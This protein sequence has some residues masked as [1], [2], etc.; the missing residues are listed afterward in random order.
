MNYTFFEKTIILSIIFLIL[1]LLF[2][3]I[4]IFNGNKF[5][6][7]IFSILSNSLLFISLSRNRS[8]FEIFFSLLLWLG[9]W[10]KLS[11]VLSFRDYHKNGFFEYA[12]SN[13]IDTSNIDSDL[14]QILLILSIVFFILNIFFILRKRILNFNFDSFYQ[15]N[16]FNQKEKNLIYFFFIN[17][18]FIFI[19]I[20]INDKFL[21]FKKGILQNTNDYSNFFL[22]LKWYLIFGF[23]S[24]FSFILFEFIKTAKKST[25]F[26]ILLVYFSCIYFV[27]I[28]SNSRSMPLILI[29][30]IVG[31]IFSFKNLNKNYNKFIF[32]LV[33]FF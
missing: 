25:F 27:S 8:F 23:Y 22:I 19:I 11:F 15:V 10:F 29:V 6:Y 16:N 17:L 32:L 14:S 4:Y 28:S 3:T 21:F 9:F 1:A 30:I 24:V 13:F 18:I 33:V 12:T 20:Y 5:Y 2:N 26:L 7:L 31:I